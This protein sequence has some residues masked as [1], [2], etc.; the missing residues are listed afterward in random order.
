[1]GESKTGMAFVRHEYDEAIAVQQGIVDA[2][3]ALVSSHPRPSARKALKAALREDRAAL[4]TLRQ[5]GKPAGATGAVEDVAGGLL[6]LMEATLK[7]VSE[8]GQDS[9]VYEAHAV[10]LTLKR[11]QMDS[12]SAM[13][14]VATA[15]DDRQL[16]EAAPGLARDQRASSTVLARELGAFAKALAAAGN[17]A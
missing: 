8:T 15:V 12:A 14:R 7:S 16:R 13:R 4:N 3:A 10:L 9:D 11:K 17:P 2:E 6:E 1:M 5:L